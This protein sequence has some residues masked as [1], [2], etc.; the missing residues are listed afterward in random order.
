MAF[1]IHTTLYV[2]PIREIHYFHYLPKLVYF[3]FNIF[4]W[5]RGVTCRAMAMLT[6]QPK[7]VLTALGDRPR[8]ENSLE[9]ELVSATRGRSSATTTQYR[10]A[11]SEMPRCCVI[12]GKG[13]KQV[14]NL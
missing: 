11:D 9:K 10:T 3:G 13:G 1:I 6:L 2:K 8:L 4:K 5:Q 14:K 12:D 7:D